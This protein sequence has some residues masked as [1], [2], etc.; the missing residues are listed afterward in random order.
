MARITVSFLGGF[1]ARTADGT[2]IR[3]PPKKAQ[4]LLAYLALPPGRAHPRDTLGALLW[5]RPDGRARASLRQ[6]LRRLALTL[7]GAVVCDASTVALDPA[8][9]DV[10]MVRLESLVRAGTPEA[11]AEV[12]ALYRGDLLEGIRVS[13]PAFEEWLLT[14]RER[15][16]EL[17][18]DALARLLRH[19]RDAAE[20]EA[21]IRTA[22]RLVAFDATEEVVHRTLMR[23]YVRA[24][25]RGAALRQYQLCVAALE[26]E[27]GVEPELET[28]LLYREILERTPRE[29]T[30]VTTSSGHAGSDR[31][32]P[33]PGGVLE[34]GVGVHETDLIGRDADL[35]R[36]RR[37]LEEARHG[38]R[39]I[40][41]VLG[42][43]GIGKTRL[44]EELAADAVR[45]G[46]RVLI[47]RAHESE[48]LLPLNPW[49]DAIRPALAADRGTLERG[50][51]AVSRAELAR[52]FPELDGSAD[53]ATSAPGNIARLFEAIVRLIARVAERRPLLLVL[54]DL[55]WADEMSLSLLAFAGRRLSGSRVLVLAT[56]RDEDV[57]ESSALSQSLAE[58]ERERCADVVTLSPLSRSDTLR[59]VRALSRTGTEDSIV[60]RFG[61]AIWAVSEGNPFAVVE[62]MR[63]IQDATRAD[64]VRAVPIPVRVRDL[65]VRRVERLSPAALELL[66]LAAVIG[67]EF[68]FRLLR[69]AAELH[70]RA[71]AEAMEEL[72]RKRLLHEIGERF[73]FTHDRIR[74]VVD[75]ALIGPARERLHAA[76]GR[77]L[78]TLYADDLDQVADRLAY[79]YGNTA[80]AEKAVTYLI[81]VG[82]TAAS[83]YAH[84]G[85][86]SL[87]QQALERLERLRA[88][89]RDRRALDIVVRLAPSLLVLGRYR[90]A[91]ELLV[92]HEPRTGRVSDTAATA[93]Y[94]FW[95]GYFRDLLGDPARGA[96]DL[97]RALADAECAGDLAT[98]GKTH[99]ELARAAFWTAEPRRGLEHGRHAAAILERTGE[100][101][102]H[103]RAHWAVGINQGM[104]GDFG[105]ALDALSRAGAIADDIG[106]PALQSYA[107]FTRGWIDAMRGETRAA[108]EAC[109]RAV[110]RSPSPG[111][112]RQALGFLGYALAEAGDP[113][114]AV[115]VLEQS[116]EQMARAGSRAYHGWMMAVLAEAYARVGRLDDA[117]AGASEALEITNG[118]GFRYGTGVARR[119]LGRAAAA[120]GDLHAATQHLHEAVRT[121]ASI[122][123]RFEADRTR[124]TLGVR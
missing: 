117:R 108:V 35:D 60:A 70:E 30:R 44:V 24:G 64:D 17:A 79:H 39:R 69:C 98:I 102:W 107:A 54:E 59:L 123:A 74:R 63:A 122:D 116:V 6:T 14:E 15:L 111:V 66:R 27:L 21:A 104:L 85:A 43:A 76:L 28:K 5:E 99:Y 56:A 103:G 118:V 71:A 45:R 121:F 119:A 34:A 97:R 112:T 8:R 105:P 100:R 61:G 3:C 40:A 81:G 73:E 65:I 26:R 38:D 2:A 86:V 84:E 114:E 62:T 57:A 23:L 94:R 10:D 91:L 89:V 96:E 77:A 93:P 72:V 1:A 41:V 11:L 82:A 37:A 83:R 106:D 22:V 124:A 68:E 67:R 90:E 33:A 80:D 52:V 29:S 113:G 32:R 95:L 88:T 78:E 75:K 46:W 25:R 20:P 48:R 58:L 51:D 42:E 12:A 16:R 4:A 19:E 50:V 101:W 31:R 110:D 120:N 115:R 49:S 13:E 9:V 7:P 47:G 109:R 18:I 87:F 55:Q 92:E 53:D 36:V